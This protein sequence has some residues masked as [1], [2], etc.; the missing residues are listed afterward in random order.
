MPSS[1]SARRKA[2]AALVALTAIA[3]GACRV[4]VAVGLDSDPDG[5]G[6]VR[7]TAT[8]DAEAVQELVG[9]AAG[10][11]NESDPATRIKVDDLR[12][13]GWT[14]DVQDPA[15]T[16]DGR[17]VIVATHDYDDEDEARRLLVDLGPFSDV[18]V[19]QQKSFAK[20]TTTFDATVDLTSGLT[21]FTDADLRQA[22][23]ATDDAP[24]GVTQQQLE[25]RLGRPLAEM[26]G[27]EVEGTLPG[28][29]TGTPSGT[30]T[31][32][33]RLVLDAQAERWNV[34]NLAAL[35]VAATSGLALAAALLVRRRRPSP[36][37]DHTPG[38]A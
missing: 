29:T 1:S 26:F 34:A 7:A 28:T 20:T 8:L 19:T 32:G 14:V 3:T 38:R 35:A 6:T 22:L 10:D 17:L 37:P 36:D 4:D 27:L 13:A 31:L 24:L 33:Q 2:T 21:A 18:A 30:V 9:R 16:D 15:E 5:T 25:A 23:E 11:P 12:E